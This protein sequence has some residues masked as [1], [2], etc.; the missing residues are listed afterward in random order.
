MPIELS[1]SCGKQLQV[2]EEF[3]GRQGQCPACGGLLRIPERKDTMPTET[4]SSDVA[5][6]AVFAATGLPS[7]KG[8]D[9]PEDVVTRTAGSAAELHA[10]ETGASEADDN[11]KL[12]AAGCVLTLLSVAVIVGVALPIVRWRDPETGLPLPRSMAILSP[13]LIGAAFHGIGSF[14]L[15]FLGLPVWS[16]RE[17]GA[18]K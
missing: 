11:G 3:S 4:P 5:A 8:P 7:P 2:S 12:T 15:K 17:M 10:R 14:L 16:K 6:Q 18:E 1:C 9:A 13:L